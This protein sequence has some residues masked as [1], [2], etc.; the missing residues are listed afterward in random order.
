[1]DRKA[2]IVGYGQTKHGFLPDRDMKDLL[3][4]AYVNALKYTGVDPKRIQQVWLSHYPTHADM[5]MTAG[6]PTVDAIGLGSRVGCITIEQACASGGQAL[7]DAALAIESGYYDL[8]LLMGVGKLMDSMVPESAPWHESGYNPLYIHAGINLQEPGGDIEYF[9][10]Y[11]TLEDQAAWYVNELWYASKHPNSLCYN[12]RI[13]TVDERVKIGYGWFPMAAGCAATGSDGASAIILA[14]RD[15]AKEYTDELIYVASVSHKE[16]SSYYS[17]ACDHDYGDHK[18]E[19]LILDSCVLRN[20]WR[21]AFQKAKVKPEDLDVYQPHDCIIQFSWAFM[22]ALGHRD[23]PRGAAP[24]FYTEGQT[25]PGG[26]LP[27]DT[28]GSAKFGQARGAVG[29]NYI[30]ENYMQLK[31]EAGKWQCP[32]KNGVAAS[33]MSIGRPAVSVIMR[34][35]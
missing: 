17:A 4:E 3:A 35:R 19:Y 34:E 22:E 11:V 24:K 1:M 6:Q 5:Q 2:Y 16:E 21:E 15:V 12:E 33:G 27:C 23:L 10:K 20:T 31:Q 8:V 29:L 32:I 14:S 18:A 9:K 13:P 30:I 7:H 25:Y 26:K 28:Q